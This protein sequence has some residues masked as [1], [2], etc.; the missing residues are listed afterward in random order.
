MIWIPLA[1]QAKIVSMYHTEIIATIKMFLSS[2][3]AQIADGSNILL[4]QPTEQQTHYA[5]SA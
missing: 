3:Y 2:L 1:I 4:T 5:I